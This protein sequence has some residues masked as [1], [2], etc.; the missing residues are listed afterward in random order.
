MNDGRVRGSF[1]DPCG[2]VFQQDG[3]VYRQVNQ[4]Y[5]SNYTRLLSSGLYQHLTEE[6]LLI[7]HSEVD[8]TPPQP[9]TAYRILRP[10]RIP[11]VSYPYEWCFSQLKDAA[12][13]TL[14]V[15]KIAVEHGMSLRDSSAFNIQ[16]IGTSPVLIDSLSFEE[17]VEGRPWVGYRQFCQHF[18][19]PLAVMAFKDVRLSR[20][21]SLFLDGIP[22]DLASKLLP[23]RSRLTISL[24]THIHLHSRL[25][26]RYAK[27]VRLPREGVSKRAMLGII[28]S[29]ESGVRRLRKSHSKTIWTDYYSITNYSSEDFKAKQQFVEDSLKAINSREVW[30][31]G[32]NTGVFS[33]IASALGAQTVAFDSDAGIVEKNYVVC[34]ERSTQRTLPLVM[35]LCSPTPSVGWRLAERQSLLERGPAETVLALALV[36]HLAIGNNVRLP[37]LAKFFAEICTFLI[38]EFVP[39]EDSQVQRMLMSREDIFMDYTREAFEREFQRV[40]TV[41]TSAMLSQSSRTLYLMRKRGV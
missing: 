22:L 19:A 23:F 6:S 37:D 7:R 21:T 16:F 30:D 20:L 31:L 32:A 33:E 1:R 25:Q 27:P 14:G 4:N 9:E 8:I 26:K 36:H 40:F 35:D 5:R 13:T 3:I 17:Y 11:F 34:R 10:E 28:R 38:V 39:K 15:Q 41:E 18:L 2:F 29:L 24:L 12:L